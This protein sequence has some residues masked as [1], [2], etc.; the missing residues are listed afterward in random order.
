MAG[1]NRGRTLKVSTHL[2][3]DIAAPLVNIRWEWCGGFLGKHSERE[4]AAEDR[5]V[6]EVRGKMESDGSSLFV[7]FP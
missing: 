7:F 3:P 2:P 4:G 6:E 5:G 1:P